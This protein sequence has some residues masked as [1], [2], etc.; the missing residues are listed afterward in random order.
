MK[1]TVDEIINGIVTLI[2]LKTGIKKYE[3][4]D[5]MPDKLEENDVVIYKNDIYFKDENQKKERL[6]II[7]KKMKMLK[8]INKLI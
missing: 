2:D 7:N 6:D 5:I 4:I 1:Y 3:N 8:N